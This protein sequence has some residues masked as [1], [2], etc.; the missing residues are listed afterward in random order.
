MSERKTGIEINFS[1]LNLPDISTPWALLT[2]VEFFTLIARKAC[3]SGIE[4]YPFRVPHTQLRA[5]LLGGQTLQS[6]HS[7][8]QSFRTEKNFAE[9]RRHPN[10]ILATQA[11]VTMPEKFASLSDLEKLQRLLGANLGLV[12][13]PPNEWM[14]ETTPAIFSRLKNKSIQ[15]APELL[16]AWGV[17]TTEEFLQEVQ[18]RGFRLC[19][20]LFHLRRRATQGFQTQFGPWQE[21]LPALLPLADEIHLAVGRKDFQAPFDSMQ[22]LKDLYSGDRRTEITSILETVKDLSWAGLVVTEIPATAANNLVSEA[23]L[24]TPSNLVRVH[25]QVAKNVKDILAS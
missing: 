12:V 25:K 8:H 17:N 18:R 11:F 9:V 15:P 7:A 3:C 1:M 16:G 24:A 13:Y 21:V 19:I 20:D 2:P 23:K 5:G 14:G 22:E 4:Y 10:P 6:I